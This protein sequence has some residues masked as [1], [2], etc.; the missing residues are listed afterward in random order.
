[1][2]HDLPMDAEMES[3]D[4]RQ[5]EDDERRKLIEEGLH[6][7]CAALT[8]GCMLAEHKG[9]LP[10]DGFCQWAEDQ[11]NAYAA[12]MIQVD[13]ARGW[14]QH[15]SRDMAPDGRP[16]YINHVPYDEWCQPKG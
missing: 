13:Q 11:V 2:S 3:P 10:C 6:P 12:A 15:H 16:L 14:T 1:M 8:G 5:A 9:Y 4:W 7:D